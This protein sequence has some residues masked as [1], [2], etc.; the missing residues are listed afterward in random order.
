[1]LEN[2]WYSEPQALETLQYLSWS[3]I[4]KMHECEKSFYRRYILGKKPEDTPAKRLGRIIHSAMLEPEKFKKLYVRTPV[5]DEID[6]LIDTVSDIKDALEIRGVEFKKSAKKADLVELL[7]EADP[8]AKHMIWEFIMEEWEASLTEES[9]RI[10]NEDGDKIVEM[11]GS[12]LEHPLAAKM[13]KGSVVEPNGYWYDKDLDIYWLIKPD[14][15]KVT[16]TKAMICDFK[17]TKSATGES[18][19]KSVAEYGYHIQAAMYIDI[20]ERIL[21]RKIDEYSFVICETSEPY[22]T[23]VKH[24]NGAD[25]EIGRQIYV[26]CAKKIVKA[27]REHQKGLKKY[28]TGY[29]GKISSEEVVMPQWYV[30]RIQNDSRYF[31]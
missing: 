15:L 4:M 10:K 1:M 26:T 29:S 22:V 7:L 13:M 17:T 23:E 5:K 18:F 2:G 6:G 25:I 8:T 14:I 12:V 11:L 24:L 9:I 28:W 20:A 16:K 31:L 19:G 27:M 21:G 3:K 30:N